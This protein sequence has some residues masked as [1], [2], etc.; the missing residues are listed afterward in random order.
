M[1]NLRN[2]LA[3][4]NTSRRADRSTVK[5][6]IASYLRAFPDR[7]EDVA[8]QLP[9]LYD[10]MYTMLE[11]PQAPKRLRKPKVKPQRDV[12]VPKSHYIPEYAKASYKWQATNIARSMR[13]RI[14]SGT[15]NL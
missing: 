4:F 1:S 2:S 15:I 11:K 9:D 8:R 7:S 5:A 14:E 6:F 3:G 12:W 10:W 13:E